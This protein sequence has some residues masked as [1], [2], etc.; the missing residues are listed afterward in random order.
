MVRRRTLGLLLLVCA[1]DNLCFDGRVTAVPMRPA[2]TPGPHWDTTRPQGE[3]AMPVDF[4]QDDAVAALGPEEDEDWDWAERDAEMNGMHSARDDDEKD[5][6]ADEDERMLEWV[7]DL[8]ISEAGL[9]EERENFEIFDKN[10]DAGV[11]L[12]EWLFR[13]LPPLTDPGVQTEVTNA[14]VGVGD[15]HRD[16]AAVARWKKEFLAADKNKNGSL[17][18]DEWQA[19]LFHQEP[20][21]AAWVDGH[22]PD[23]LPPLTE[24]LL[25]QTFEKGDADGDAEL[26]PVELATVLRLVYSRYAEAGGR[27]DLTKVGEDVVAQI[28]EDVMSDLDLDRSGSVSSEEFLAYGRPSHE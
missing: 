18:W 4:G 11:D 27:G 15:D 13:L 6:G 20:Q 19:M 7:D 17:C 21:A 8:T 23:A 28:A 24:D 12:D 22:S 26:S 1:C 16:P 3:T 10:Q 2:V 14:S 5:D 9:Q 25:L